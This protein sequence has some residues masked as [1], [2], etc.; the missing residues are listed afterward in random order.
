[1]KM[2][3]PSNVTKE[4]LDFTYWEKTYEKQRRTQ[5]RRK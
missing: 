1:M 3:D 4:E 2:K 5:M